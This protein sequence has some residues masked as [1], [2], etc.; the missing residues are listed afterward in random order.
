MHTAETI[1]ISS[2]FMICPW[3]G[4]SGSSGFGKPVV[5]FAWRKNL[6]Q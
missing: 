5:L 3:L 2:R 6:K 4:L 1:S